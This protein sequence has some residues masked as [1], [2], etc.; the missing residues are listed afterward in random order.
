[1]PALS[2]PAAARLFPAAF[3]AILVTAGCGSSPEP[4]PPPAEER[5]TDFGYLDV[6]AAGDRDAEFERDLQA[7]PGRFAVAWTANVETSRYGPVASL[8]N[9]GDSVFV[10]TRGKAVQ[11][12][13]EGGRSVFV[14]DRIVRPIDPLYPPLVMDAGGRLGQVERFVA[15]P[16]GNGFTLLTLDGEDIS[17]TAVD[18]SLTS[19]AFAAGGVAYVGLADDNGGRFVKADPTRTYV[20]VLE[21]VLFPRGNVVARPAWQSNVVYAA[22]TSG[23]VYGLNE[24]LTRAWPQDFFLTEPGREVEADLSV[25]PYALYVA[26]TD[27]TLYALDRQRGTVKWK[28]SAGRALYD[29]PIPTEQYVYLPVPDRGVAAIPKFEGSANNRQ[30]AWTAEGAVDFLS[31]DDRRVY[32]LHR[33]G[34]MVAHDKETGEELFRSERRDLR[35]FARNETGPRIYAA[36]LDGEVLAIDPT[37]G[38]DQVGEFAD[39][40]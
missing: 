14:T 28:H 9:R 34:S 16:T 32:L 30:P 13:T 2:A 37:V 33:D 27:G 25:D 35:R 12:I 20:P 36:T 24:D 8:H 5:A 11:R 4:A 29:R 18:Q 17:E 23:R 22:D 6:T 40:R 1:M 26:G 21:R 31:H 38:F 39:A 15:F 3:A 10:Y 7:E 19:P